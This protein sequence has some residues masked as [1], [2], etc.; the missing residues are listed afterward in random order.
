MLGDNLE[1]GDAVGGRREVHEGGNIYI[2]CGRFMLM[3]GRN[4]HNIVKQ[5]S[6][7]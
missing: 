4:Q 5:L 7:N 1:G 3:C 2:T 6:S